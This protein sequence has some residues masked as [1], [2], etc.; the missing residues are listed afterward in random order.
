M[1][2]GEKTPVDLLP[3]HASLGKSLHFFT[4]GIP[5]DEAAIVSPREQCYL[6]EMRQ[7]VDSSFS[8]PNHLYAKALMSFSLN[9]KKI[10]DS[11]ALVSNVDFPGDFIS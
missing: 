2:C 5:V 10:T 3:P 4:P 11:E 1:G 9:S 8:V 6:S 7:N